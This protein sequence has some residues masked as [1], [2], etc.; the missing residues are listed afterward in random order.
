M[1]RIFYFLFWHNSG[2]DLGILCLFC[3]SINP[4]CVDCNSCTLWRFKRTMWEK[5]FHIHPPLDLWF[6]WQWVSEESRGCP[7]LWPHPTSFH[8]PFLPPSDSWL[9]LI[10]QW[11]PKQA[12]KQSHLTDILPWDFQQPSNRHRIEWEREAILLISLFSLCTL[13]AGTQGE[14]L[15]V[16]HSPL[17][18][19]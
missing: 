19:E 8:H 17:G 18:T 13:A 4:S 15:T 9:T 16:R 3:N 5:G 10:G 11:F 1:E 6:G 7:P 14:R 2:A 12:R